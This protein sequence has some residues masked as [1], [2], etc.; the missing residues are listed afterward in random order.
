MVSFSYL[1]KKCLYIVFHDLLL[2]LN[3]RNRN[4]KGLCSRLPKTSADFGVLTSTG[5]IR[6]LYVGALIYHLSGWLTEDAVE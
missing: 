4:A 5:R 6:I 1:D 3:I 2:F